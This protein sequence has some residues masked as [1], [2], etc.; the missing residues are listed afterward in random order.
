M[1]FPSSVNTWNRL[2][3]TCSLILCFSHK[4]RQGC[5]WMSQKPSVLKSNWKLDFI[6]INK[7]LQFWKIYFK[8]DFTH[9]WSTTFCA[10]FL[11]D[12]FHHLIFC[13]FSLL[14][15]LIWRLFETHMVTLTRSPTHNSASLCKMMNISVQI[16]GIKRWRIIFPIGASL[17]WLNCG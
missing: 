1:S 16:C 4:F 14:P 9:K 7:C 8:I 2:L 15:L 5:V 10:F 17:R 3:F 11:I 12:I 13:R 6:H